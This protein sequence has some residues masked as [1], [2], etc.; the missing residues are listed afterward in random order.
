MFLALVM[1]FKVIMIVY[2]DK[3]ITSRK[4]GGGDPKDTSISCSYSGFFL[5]LRGHYFINYEKRETAEMIF[6]SL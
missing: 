6:V 3:C 4:R 1:Y 5:L 2:C